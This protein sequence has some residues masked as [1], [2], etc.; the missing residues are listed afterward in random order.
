MVLPS[1]SAVTSNCNSGRELWREAQDC[2][3]AQQGGLLGRGGMRW[4]GTFWDFS[5]RASPCSSP[6]QHWLALCTGPCASPGLEAR[7]GPGARSENVCL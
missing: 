5:E 1:L 4:A 2:G 7:L 6:S 3:Q